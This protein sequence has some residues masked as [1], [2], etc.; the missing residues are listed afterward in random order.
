MVGNLPEQLVVH[1]AV[2]L[3]P[4]GPVRAHQAGGQGF[5]DIVMTPQLLRRASRR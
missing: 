4:L 1:R 3:S 2:D 5:L